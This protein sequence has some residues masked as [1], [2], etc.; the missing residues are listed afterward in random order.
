MNISPQSYLTF[1]LAQ[2]G[3]PYLYGHSGPDSFDCSGL[4]KA[5]IKF[6]GGPDLHRLGW[7]ARNLYDRLKSVK[8]PAARQI[9]LSF[10]GSETSEHLHVMTVTGDGRVF[11]A[12]GG[13][14]TTTTL[15]EAMRV[16]A[17]VRYRP[18]VRYR[19]PDDFLGYRLLELKDDWNRPTRV[20]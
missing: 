3:K 4:V 14:H 20:G 17:R 15:S 9:C 1:I 12:S 10:Y 11:G 19:Q 6:A 16:G 7:N 5:G 8:D 18:A 13:D 2:N